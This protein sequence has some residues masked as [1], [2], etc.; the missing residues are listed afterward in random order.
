MH[1]NTKITLGGTIFI[2]VVAL[3]VGIYYLFIREKPKE[4]NLPLI[5]SMLF[6]E[7]IIIDHIC[8]DIS[9]I[10]EHWIRK[11]RILFRISYGHTSH[12]SQIV[13][14]MEVLMAKSDLYSLLGF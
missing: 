10:P 3:G 6:S 13:S 4:I 11:A 5:S 1:V 8:T 14:G 12:G 7:P 2:A 9:Q